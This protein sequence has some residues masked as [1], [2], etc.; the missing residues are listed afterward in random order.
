MCSRK[1]LRMKVLICSVNVASADSLV[2]G[3]GE[4][5]VE[6][7]QWGCKAAAAGS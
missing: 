5:E 1:D 3:Q 7:E 6:E 2:G 4:G